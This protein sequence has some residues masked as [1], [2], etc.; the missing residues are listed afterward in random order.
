M[1]LFTIGPVQMYQHTLDLRGRV[2]PY[3]R[4]QEFSEMMLETSQLLKKL[5]GTAQN[6][7][8]IYL[9]ASGT[10]AMEASV[11]NCIGPNDKALVI[12]GG[13]F[14][15]RFVDICQLHNVQHDAL[16]VE[17]GRTLTP[18]L[19][20]PY[21]AKGYT[22]LLVNLH[23]TSTGQLYNIELLSDFC[24]R[25]GMTLIVDAISTFLCDPYQMDKNGIDVTILSSHKGLC[26]SPGLSM[27]VLNPKMAERLKGRNETFSLYF[28]YVSYLK[29]V[30]RG[31][32]PFTPAVGVLCEL[33]DMLK[34]ISRIGLNKRLQEVLEKCQCFRDSIQ[35]KGVAIPKYPLSNALTPIVFDRDIAYDT[36]NYL[37]DEFSIF[38]NPTGGD[39]GK[40]VLR[41]AHVGDNSVED[42]LQL[43]DLIADYV[44]ISKKIK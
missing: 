19:L 29:D 31:Q 16:T 11:V 3:F 42:H 2:V 33:N 23:E 14:G 13:T 20:S 41:I 10:A 44:A 24:R 28:D 5:V 15:Q 40:R 27:V 35:A 38:T 12:N 39:F 37:K 36:F 9:T 7:E 17:F 26:L 8:V 30:A 25:N 22:V 32:T 1:R 34:V 18:D 21:D 6:S 43:A 4:T